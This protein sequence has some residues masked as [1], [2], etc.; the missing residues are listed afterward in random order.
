MASLENTNNL[1]F[2]D[3]GGSPESYKKNIQMI[4]SR[5]PVGS[6]FEPEPFLLWGDRLTTASL[7]CSHP[8]V[9]KVNYNQ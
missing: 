3:I 9:V 6:R 5:E 8:V 1:A 7:C 2:M 4:K